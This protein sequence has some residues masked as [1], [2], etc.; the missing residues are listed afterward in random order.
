MNKAMSKN[1]F[2]CTCGH[3]ERYHSISWK[4]SWPSYEKCQFVGCNCKHFEYERTE[5]EKK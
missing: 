1:D 5:K 4:T 2:L 3:L